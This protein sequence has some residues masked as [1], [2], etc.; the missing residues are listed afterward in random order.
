M[1]KGKLTPRMGCTERGCE[2]GAPP[3]GPSSPKVS[4]AVTRV[5]NFC[6][7]SL[8]QVSEMDPRTG[9]AKAKN[10]HLLTSIQCLWLPLRF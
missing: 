2:A 7:I 5:G 3:S 1:Q 9:Q 10:T 4:S 8:V 6:S